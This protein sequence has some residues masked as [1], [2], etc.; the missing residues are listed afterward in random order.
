MADNVAITAG[1][2]TSIAT[3]DIAGVQ[4]QRVKVTYGADGSATDV[5]TASPLPVSAVELSVSTA[6]PQNVAASASSTTLFASNSSA[7]GRA[8]WNDSTA[9]L[10][11]KFGAT[12][13]ATSCTVKIAADGYYEFPGPL[14]TGV[15]DGI[16]ASA[17]GAARVTEW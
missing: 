9:V 6:S 13:S 4:Y 11:L 14:Y 17:A 2:G 3:D 10:Y 16:W 8:I 1:S 7:R 12:A 5:S 15:V